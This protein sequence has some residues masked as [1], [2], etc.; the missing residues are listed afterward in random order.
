MKLNLKFYQKNPIKTKQFEIT[1]KFIELVENQ[2]KLDP[3]EYFWAHNRFK[4][5]KSFKSL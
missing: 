4:H 3:S 2:I 5:S 1:N